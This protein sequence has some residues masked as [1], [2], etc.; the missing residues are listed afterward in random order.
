MFVVVDSH[1]VYYELVT[2]DFWG[3]VGCAVASGVRR[4]MGD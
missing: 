1:S 4:W 3:G 2:G